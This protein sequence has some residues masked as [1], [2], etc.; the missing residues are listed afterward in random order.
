MLSFI[1]SALRGFGVDTTKLYQAISAASVE[2]AARE[3]GLTGLREKLRQVV[4]DSSDQYTA[5]FD[6]IDFKRYWEPKMRGLHAF[7]VLCVLD[8]LKTVP[9]EGVTIADVGD[10]SG[11][12]AAYIK[13]LAP[14]G[15]VG[16]FV[17]VNLDP[18]A[19]EKVKAKGGE[20]VLCRA[21]ELSGQDIKP[22]LFLSFEM[23]E[24]LTD[25]IRFLNSLSETSDAPLL[26]SVPYRRDSRFGGEVLRVAHGSSGPLS[27][28]SLHIFELCPE[29]WK[30]LAQFAGYRCQVARI[31]RQYPLYH[32]LRIMAPLWRKLDFE[33][34]LV[35]HLTPD[36][37]V[38]NRYTGW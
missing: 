35:L 10:S 9:G 1:K 25:P 17:S 31:Y 26:I 32:P 16:R 34:F 22:D 37:S 19:V 14:Q 33:G 5:A 15:K 18:V 24:H 21:E 28:E 20:A 7:Q 12:H 3:Q 23:L 29:D 13:A 8:A 38:A 11:N 4:P 6:P 27:P 36:R 2:A 30:L